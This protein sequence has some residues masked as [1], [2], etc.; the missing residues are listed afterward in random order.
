M[1]GNKGTSKDA[2]QRMPLLA[3]PPPLVNFK[4]MYG[5]IFEAIPLPVFITDADF[6]LLWMNAAA[7]ELSSETPHEQ[8]IRP[9][10][11]LFIPEGLSFQE[12]KSHLQVADRSRPYIEFNVSSLSIK[13]KV[14]AFFVSINDVDYCIFQFIES[15]GFIESP[16]AH[17]I[18][19]GKE[20]N[21]LKNDD[22]ALEDQQEILNDLLNNMPGIVYRC[23]RQSKEWRLDYISPGCRQITGY[24]AKSL[25]GSLSLHFGRLIH[26]DDRQKVVAEIEQAVQRKRKFRIEYRMITHNKKIKWVSEYGRGQ[27]NDKNELIS[28]EGFITDITRVKVYD[29]K[30][31]QELEINQSLSALGIDLLSKSIEPDRFAR[32][33]QGHIMEYTG[34]PFS[35]FIVPSLEDDGMIYF[36]KNEAGSR[37][38]EFNAVLVA[39]KNIPFSDYLEAGTEMFQNDP[40]ITFSLQALGLDDETYSRLAGVPVTINGAHKGYFLIA[41]SPLDYTRDTID[42]INRFVHI[43]SL[44]LYRNKAEKMLQ[45]AKVKAE[46]SDK[47]KSMFLSNMSHE[48]RTPMNAIVGF[49][50]MLHEVGLESEEKDRFLDAI[51]RSGDSLLRLINDI[52]DI[53][54]IEAG[55]L[56]LVSS[57]CN[58]NGLLDE[59]ET[60]FNG[61]LERQNKSKI[62]LYIQKE[63]SD[64][65]F[66]IHTDAMRLRQVLS[67][68]VGNAIKFTD[69]GFIEIGYRTKAGKLLFYVRDSGVGISKEDQAVI[70]ERFG[71]VESEHERNFTGT[72]LGLTISKNII[73]ML[74]GNIWVESIPGEGSTFWFDL[75]LIRV[76]AKPKE[77]RLAKSR[78]PA[79]NLAGKSILVV[80]DVDTN[81][82]YISTLLEKL[83]AKVVRA[84]TGQKAV[85][86]CAENSEINLVMMDI[87]L[88]VMNGYEATKIIKK[89]RP[90][91]PIIAQ[92]AYAMAG[93]RE[94]SEEAGCDD[95]LAKP[96]RK[97]DMID[98]ISRLI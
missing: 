96:I 79:I 45:V 56:K 52:I 44:G 77:I 28:L 54:K 38:I 95:Y 71:Q 69:E 30:L 42:I 92:T 3:N 20:V 21:L 85:D 75:P 53:S 61:E 43:F 48:I 57:A 91:L 8:D 36:L 33:V 76:S 73:G 67:N 78:T 51:T 19:S 32:E 10:S 9:I 12:I 62:S 7:E 83:N 55:Q 39:A 5:E 80:E 35:V 58:V 60:D 97:D 14:L 4:A 37:E 74:S 15:S 70:F 24:S 89:S 82:F 94:R 40:S 63:F 88:P 1:T 29:T 2:G 23:S 68:L 25:I 59:L 46:K 47:M 27:M 6:F 86:I 93:E 16:S 18:F 72:G 31:K 50:D 66:I 98:A 81:Y 49:A 65:D 41:G 22:E 26:P 34:S 84:V 11:E 64:Q 17:V 90:N 87:E 13:A